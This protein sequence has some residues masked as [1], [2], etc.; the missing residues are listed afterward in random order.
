MNYLYGMRLRGFS[1]GAQPMTKHVIERRDDP[2]G[3]YHDI[4]VYDIR[5]T[6][7]Q[8][9]VYDLDF[10]GTVWRETVFGIN[11]RRILKERG[12][13]QRV[14]AKMIGKKQ[15]SVSCWCTGRSEPTLHTLMQIKKSL[16]VTWDD[17]LEERNE[18]GQGD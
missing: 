7:K 2:S 5:L 12:I 10:I 15:D 11:L 16:K 14:F 9:L 1:P 3:K 17:L 13:T 18:S 8:V 4:L 6:R